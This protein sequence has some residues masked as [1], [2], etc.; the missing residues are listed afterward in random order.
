MNVL[1]ATRAYVD[2]IVSD[3]NNP[4]MKVLLSDAETTKTVANVYS[5][6]EILDRDVFLV[7]RLDQARGHEPMRHLKAAAFVRPTAANLRF[8]TEGAADP[9]FGEYH[10]FANV[11]PRAQLRELA[12]SDDLEVVRQVQEFYADF[13]PVRRCFIHAEPAPGAAP[14][15]DA[16]HRRLVEAQR[17]RRALF[18]TSAEGP[19]RDDPLLVGL[20]GGQGH[21][22]G[23]PAR[24]RR[25]RH[26]PL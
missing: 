2:R 7:E 24:R 5:Q 11:A 25:G 1:A 21:R 9:R 15:H 19:A 12:E 6:T 4:G 13:V 26:L 20:G 14:E 3:P 22:D 16:A 10:L 17:R 18:F 8:A 23:G